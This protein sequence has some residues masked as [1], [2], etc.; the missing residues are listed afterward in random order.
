MVNK[1]LEIYSVVGCDLDY[2]SD[3]GDV[4]IYRLE[5]RTL[6]CSVDETDDGVYCFK[7][8][9]GDELT[10]TIQ[11]LFELQEEGEEIFTMLDADEEYVFDE[12]IYQEPPIDDDDYDT[13]WGREEFFI[14]KEDALKHY[15]EELEFAKNRK[16]SAGININLLWY[17][18]N[19][20]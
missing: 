18:S 5:L 19:P 13:K 7:S 11:E 17:S 4:C 2:T 9:Y 14:S 12:G 1:E 3:D 16:H 20:R 10:G 8:D 6:H 15:K